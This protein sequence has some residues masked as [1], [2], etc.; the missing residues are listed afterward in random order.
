MRANKHNV[1]NQ[2]PGN[3]YI[4]NILSGRLFCHRPDLMRVAYNPCETFG[5]GG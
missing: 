5:A 3:A 1:D 2:Y 4:R